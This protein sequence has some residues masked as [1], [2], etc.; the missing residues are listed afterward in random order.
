MILKKTQ[1]DTMAKELREHFVYNEFFVDPNKN[2]LRKLE[3][4]IKFF[5]EDDFVLHIKQNEQLYINFKEKYE[6]AVLLIKNY[7]NIGEK[8][9]NNN[10]FHRRSNSRTNKSDSSHVSPKILY[11]DGVSIPLYNTN[12]SSEFQIAESKPIVL[13]KT[14][15]YNDFENLREDYFNELEEKKFYKA[16]LEKFDNLLKENEELK[17]ANN[18]YLYKINDFNEKQTIFNEERKSFNDRCNKTSRE[19]YEMLGE[20]N[21]LREQMNSLEKEKLTL[22]SKLNSLN[23]KIKLQEKELNSMKKK[24]QTLNHE[25]KNLKEKLEDELFAKNNI[26]KKYIDKLSHFESYIVELKNSNFNLTKENI[27][28]SL[29]KLS[30]NEEFSKLIDFKYTEEKNMVELFFENIKVTEITSKKLKDVA[31]KPQSVSPRNFFLDLSKIKLIHNDTQ[32][33]PRKRNSHRQGAD[34]KK[35]SFL[36]SRV[37]LG[38]PLKDITNINEIVPR[39]PP[40]QCLS[41]RSPQKKFLTENKENYQPIYSK[42]FSSSKKSSNSNSRRSK[43]NPFSLIENKN[44]V[45]NEYAVIPKALSFRKSEISED[46]VESNNL[47]EHNNDNDKENILNSNTKDNIDLSKFRYIFS[48]QPIR[49]KAIC[50]DEILSKEQS[51]QIATNVKFSKNQINEEISVNQFENEEKHQV[52]IC[53]Y[54]IQN[55]EKI[56]LINLSIQKYSNLGIS[57]MNDTYLCSEND[58]NKTIIKASDRNYSINISNNLLDFS[59][60]DNR[61]REDT[62]LETTIFEGLIV[63]KEYIE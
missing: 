47:Y 59:F 3:N 10:P 50:L 17:F 36:N 34:V 31:I 27:I 28:M 8:T 35:N 63:N 9:P 61:K 62:K 52:V 23:N 4:V 37:S 58:P 25:N 13:E 2:F 11:D 18:N 20:L 5:E 51:P 60:D 1:I 56:E 57:K 22:K 46:P 48:S 40:K 16:Q 39:S 7:E 49:K 33:F 30:E 26:E 41:L 43:F 55:V 14:I 24:N 32:Y 12:N 19:N 54:L 38:V 53:N 42:I 45:T 21:K 29:K 44:S 6:N 15:N